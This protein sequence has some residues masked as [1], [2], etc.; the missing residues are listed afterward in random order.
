MLFPF[1][2]SCLQLDLQRE[3]ASSIPRATLYVISSPHGHDS[4]LIEIKQL[5]DAITRWLQLGAREGT[6]A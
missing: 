6:A 4:F 2:L 1:R 3:M 5:N